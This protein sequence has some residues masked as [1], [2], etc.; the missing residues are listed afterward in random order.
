MGCS[1]RSWLRGSRQSELANLTMQ[2]VQQRDNRWCNCRSGRQTWS[3]ADDP[4][5]GGCSSAAVCR[6]FSGFSARS[7]LPSLS[8]AAVRMLYEE[9]RGLI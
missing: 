6:K 8:M 9:V 2:H 5:A 7:P 1:P 4:D 3:R